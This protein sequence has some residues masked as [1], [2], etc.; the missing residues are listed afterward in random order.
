M[1]GQ[2]LIMVRAGSRGGTGGTCPGPGLPSQEDPA[3]D[4]IFIVCK[5]CLLDCINVPCVVSFSLLPC[6]SRLTYS[7]F[8]PYHGAPLGVFRGP[9]DSKLSLGDLLKAGPE[10]PSGG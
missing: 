5:L 1:K 4:E 7:H 10:G 8:V 3:T 9:Q 6:S 2:L